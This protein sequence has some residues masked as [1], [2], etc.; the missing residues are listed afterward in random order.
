MGSYNTT[1]ILQKSPAVSAGKA[2]DANATVKVDP[3]EISKL[4][5]L[6]MLLDLVGLIPGA[7]AP[8]DIL[9]GIISAGRGD[10]I[11]AGLSVLGA[12][13]IAG[14][15]ATAGKI[16]KNT[17]K[18]AAGLKKVAEEVLPHLPQRFQKPL[19]E[20]LEKAE[21]KLDELAGRPPKKKPDAE[22]PTAKNETTNGAKIKPK[23]TE[24]PCFHPFDKKKFMS[25]NAQEKK[26]YLK[27]M[28]SQLQKQQDQINGMSALDYKAARNAYKSVGR[29]PLAEAAQTSYRKD[30]AKE[31]SR[32]I[33]ESLRNS[34]VAR[35]AAKAQA[36]AR[37]KDIMGKLAALHEPDMVAGGWAQPD[38]KGMGRADVNGSIGG[39]WNQDGRLASMDAAA[40]DAIKNGK[41]D[42]KMNVK[43]EPCRGKDM[44]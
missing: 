19:R 28:A 13:P 4:D 29:N 40:D 30:F 35:P 34:G 12:V 6:Q 5:A 21:A 42:E 38:P 3:T 17:E 10:W 8:A 9:N 11:G 31:V 44:R 43:L 32:G 1:G 24:V 22:A 27:E 14:E 25:M 23:R 20:A 33:E 39:S 26:A 41:G 2:E 18:Y 16:A 37:T 15:A 7:G 36:A